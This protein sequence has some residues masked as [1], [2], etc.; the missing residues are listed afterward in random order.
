MRKVIDEMR[1]RV[2]VPGSK[3]TIDI[4]MIPTDKGMWRWVV[5]LDGHLVDRG[6]PGKFSKSLKQATQAANDARPE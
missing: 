6:G 4:R 3:G 2:A 5:K 1:G